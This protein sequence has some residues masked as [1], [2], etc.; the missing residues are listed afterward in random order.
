MA[1][2]LWIDSNTIIYISNGNTALEAEIIALAKQRDIYY[3]PK[4]REEARI[5]NPLKTKKNKPWQPNRLETTEVVDKTLERLPVKLDTAATKEGLAEFRDRGFFSVDKSGNKVVDVARGVSESDAVVLT[6]VAASAKARG[7]SN[8]EMLTSDVGIFNGADHKRW[9][10]KFQLPKA[11]IGN[12]PP[13]G[14]GAPP[15]VKPADTEPAPPAP[16]GRCT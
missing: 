13:Q 7:V 11:P 14:G 15:P 8:P 3:V 10:I 5:G 2:P 12:G 6:Q 9:G 1:D 16:R 4:S